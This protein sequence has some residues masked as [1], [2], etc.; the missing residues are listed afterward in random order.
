MAEE[1]KDSPPKDT[2]KTTKP[3][4][5]FLRNKWT[6]IAAVGCAGLILMIWITWAYLSP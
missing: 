2:T 1:S 3:Y 4:P 5:G 6:R